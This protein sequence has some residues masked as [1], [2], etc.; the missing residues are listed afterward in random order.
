MRAYLAGQA[1][2]VEAAGV[3][4]SELSSSKSVI[5]MSDEGDTESSL[6]RLVM[7]AIGWRRKK[8]LAMVFGVVPEPKGHLN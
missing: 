7:M 4:S 1:E 5:C 6:A 3:G 2:S 8:M